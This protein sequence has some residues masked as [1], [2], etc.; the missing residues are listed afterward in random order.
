M[1]DKNEAILE[2]MD[3]ILD[4]GVLVD[5]KALETIFL[6]ARK[7]ILSD[8]YGAL[9]S[10][11]HKLSLYLMEHDYKAPKAVINLAKQIVKEPFK[12]RGKISF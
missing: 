10:F 8:H 1:K 11:S 6:D 2:T 5:D 3:K 7:A 4:S 9:A 12:E